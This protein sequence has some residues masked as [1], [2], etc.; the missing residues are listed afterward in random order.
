LLL[1]S[2]HET[3][4]FYNV[5]RNLADTGFLNCVSIVWMHQ[6]AKLHVSG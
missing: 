1:L 6:D 4:V 3:T 5:K 2:E